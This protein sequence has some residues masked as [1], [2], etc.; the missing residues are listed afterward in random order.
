MI[1]ALQRPRQLLTTLAAIVGPIHERVVEFAKTGNQG[2]EVDAGAIEAGRSADIVPVEQAMAF[3]SA[4]PGL[5]GADGDAHLFCERGIAGDDAESAAHAVLF[6]E[7][8][9][10]LEQEAEFAVPQIP[11]SAAFGMERPGDTAFRRR[12]GLGDKGKGLRRGGRA[13]RFVNPSRAGVQI[14]G[15]GLR[16]EFFCKF[17]RR[18]GSPVRCAAAARIKS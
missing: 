16:I 7:Q 2:R 17:L 1:S 14:G 11:C 8:A 5:D 10:E 3:K 12:F 6:V 4:E 9:G 18:A 15:F 13:L